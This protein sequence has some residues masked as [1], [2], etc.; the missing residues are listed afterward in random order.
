MRISALQNARGAGLAALLLLA[1]VPAGL[2]QDQPQTP[3]APATRN[4]KIRVGV[5][6]SRAIAVAYA[7]SREFQNALKPAQRDYDQAKLSN[8][9]K[10]MNELQRQMQ[11]TQRRLNEQA[12]STASV[13]SIMATI[14]NSLPAI[15]KEANVDVIASKWEVNYLGYNTETEDVTDK[16]V[17]VFHTTE[18][19]W[20]WAKEIQQ[21]T[22]VPIEKYVEQNN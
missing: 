19:G 2:G 8:N 16:L 4:R 15:A 14:R 17:A 13:A 9:Q 3:A 11:L 1:A 10:R 20:K 21:K 5:Y 22:P 12:Y 18:Q 6:D 7:N